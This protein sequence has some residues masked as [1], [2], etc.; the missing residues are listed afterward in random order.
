MIFTQPAAKSSTPPKPKHVIVNR[1]VRW[2]WLCGLDKYLGKS[3]EH[4]KLHFL[5][6]VFTWAVVDNHMHIVVHMS[7]STANSW[8]P[9]EVAALGSALPSA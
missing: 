7:P 3:F 9:E 2:S 6:A 1:C 4:Q 8:S 5:L